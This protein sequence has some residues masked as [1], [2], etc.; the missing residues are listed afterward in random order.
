M[1]DKY[2]ISAV[3]FLAIFF[4]SYSLLFCMGYFVFDWNY[5]SLPAILFFL[6]FFLGV[7]FG[8]YVGSKINIPYRFSKIRIRSGVF[9]TVMWFFLTF[10]ILISLYLMLKKYGSIEYII[11]YAFAIREEVIGGSGFIPFYLSYANSLN[12]ALFAVS[13]V[14]YKNTGKFKFCILFF[15]NIVLC[16]LLSFGRVGTLFSIC[17]VVGFIFLCKGWKV[18]N[19]KTALYVF[20]GFFVL[21]LSRIVRGGDGGFSSS[22]NHLVPHLKFDVPE[23]MYGILSNYSYFFSSPVAFSEYLN[24]EELFKSS[25]GERLL[26]PIYNITLRLLGEQRI[27]TI[28]PFVNIPY[29][30]NIYTVLR[31]I[32]SE[33]GVFGVLPSAI[34]FGLVFGFLYNAKE[35]FSRALFLIMIGCAFFFPLYNALSFGMF[36]MSIIFL[37]LMFTFFRCG[38]K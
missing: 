8:A 32:Y 34:L 10:C 3:G 27:N 1:D 37:F 18:V 2:S 35:V 12:Q 33:I 26:T 31:D 36:L 24:N 14:I 16:D 28:D 25:F 7:L 9:L 5:L 38:D 13:M 17:M 23:W 15:I 30:T 19:L 6:L 11:S 22:V 29:S 21:N 4:L 20:L